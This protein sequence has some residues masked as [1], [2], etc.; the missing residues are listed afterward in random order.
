MGYV[1]MNIHLDNTNWSGQY[2]GSVN[3]SNNQW[4]GMYTLDNRDVLITLEVTIESVYYFLIWEVLQQMLL[5]P[6]L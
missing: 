1:M 2:G 3:W 5:V 4:G 6:H